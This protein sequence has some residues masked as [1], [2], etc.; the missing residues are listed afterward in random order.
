MSD[1]KEEN[2]EDDFINTIAVAGGPIDI[3]FKYL[4]TTG[5]TTAAVRYYRTVLIEHL[6]LTNGL[7]YI[8]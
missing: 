7:A 1:P 4:K 5:K 3:A 6:L 8:I 2:E